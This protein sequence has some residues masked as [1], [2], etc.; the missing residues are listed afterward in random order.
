MSETDGLGEALDQELRAAVMVAAQVAEYTARRAETRTRAAERDATAA[1]AHAQT[2]RAAERDLARAQVAPTRDPRWWDTARLEAAAQAYAAAHA[3][4]E[5]DHQLAAD[6]TRIAERIEA[7]YGADARAAVE[8]AARTGRS[9]G[10]L[11]DDVDQPGRRG[12]GAEQQYAAI[13]AHDTRAP[14]G[15]AASGWDT[16]QRRAA[17]ADTLRDI[18]DL[19]AVDT[20]LRLDR[21]RSHPAK[22]A[23]NAHVRYT[24]VNLNSTAFQ[25]Q[26]AEIDR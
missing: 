10:D 7:R 25:G 6:T 22:A 5:H 15:V 14:A 26:H 21:A 1:T 3:W 23:I 13:T 19:E 24:D 11:A 9:T 17:F 2:R 16:T 8:T 4:A 12:A 20:R 18:P